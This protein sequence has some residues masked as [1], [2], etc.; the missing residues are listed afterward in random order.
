MSTQIEAI[1]KK[2]PNSLHQAPI[3]QPWIPHF[4]YI[5][6]MNTEYTCAAGWLAFEQ[7]PI[8]NHSNHLARSNI[9]RISLSKHQHQLNINKRNFNF[10]EKKKDNLP[11]RSRNMPVYLWDDKHSGTN[12]R[13]VRLFCSGMC[14]IT[15]TSANF[16]HAKC[17]AKAWPAWLHLRLV[18]P[19][20]LKRTAVACLR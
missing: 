10:S 9:F 7:T 12:G 1:E 18:V 3:F 14:P 6:Q 16:F 2:I 4:K 15:L 11:T 5:K 19:P 13:S 17:A 20:C 8:L